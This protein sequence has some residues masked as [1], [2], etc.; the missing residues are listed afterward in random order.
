MAS[1]KV[2]KHELKV[3][4]KQLP[5]LRRFIPLFDDVKLDEKSMLLTYP[6]S[7]KITFKMVFDLK[8]ESPEK[9]DDN[10]I[11][12]FNIEK[13]PGFCNDYKIGRNESMILQYIS[14]G[15]LLFDHDRYDLE[16]DCNDP[17][18][19]IKAEKYMKL[20]S[21]YISKNSKFRKVT[22][23]GITA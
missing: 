1:E 9:P 19:V 12:D 10:T 5:V 4:E 14:D 11:F 7:R 6:E 15:K 2:L 17:D 16:L 18:H 3:S 8:M 23:L 13:K 21:K 22:L 20:L